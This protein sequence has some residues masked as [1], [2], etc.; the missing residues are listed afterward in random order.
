MGKNRRSLPALH[1]ILE[2]AD[3]VERR[4]EVALQEPGNQIVLEGGQQRYSIS[5]FTPTGSGQRKKAC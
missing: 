3:V 5:A 2:A 1:D 4:V